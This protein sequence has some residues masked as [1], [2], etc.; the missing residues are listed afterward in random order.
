MKTRI[1]LLSFLIVFCVT[2]NASEYKSY[3]VK[4][5][6]N[7]G[8]LI[9][10][11]QKK[12]MINAPFN[13]GGSW[14]VIVPS[15]ETLN[16]I[17]TAQAPFNNLD[18]IL[19]THAHEDHYNSDMLE[20]TML[21]NP[22]AWLVVPPEL[23]TILENDW[24]NFES[25]KNRIVHP[26][27]AWKTSEELS[28]N[29]VELKIYCEKHHLPDASG[30]KN[31]AY[32][33]NLDGYKILHN[34]ASSSLDY[35]GEYNN[36]DMQNENIDLAILHYFM[37]TSN[38]WTGSSTLSL[39][40]NKVEFV[41]QY[42]NPKNIELAHVYYMNSAYPLLLD[43]LKG[44]ADLP[45]VHIFRN[46]L[47]GKIY[48]S[49]SIDY[50]GQQSPGNTPSLF[51]PEVVSV[52][53]RNERCL[54]VSPEGDELFFSTF[55]NNWDWSVPLYY[56]KENDTWIEKDLPSN[57]ADYASFTEPFFSPDGRRLY[58]SCNEPGDN[59]KYNNRLWVISK[60]NTAW[61]DPVL[62]PAA[63]NFHK[64]LW[65]PSIADNEN[66][67]FAYNGRI[68]CAEF[69]DGAYQNAVPL[70]KTINAGAQNWDPYIDPNEQFILFKSNKAGGYGQ[71]DMYISFKNK[72]HEWT[73]LKNFGP[74]INNEE[75]NDA[76][77]VTPDGKY[78]TYSVI[79]PNNAT[80][81]Y[82]VEFAHLFDSLRSSDYVPYLKNEIEDQV[83]QVNKRFSFKFSGY[84]IDDGEEE[85]SYTAT[86]A[87]GDPLPEWLELEQ[88]YQR[89]SG[90]PTESES[91]EVQLSAADSMNAPLSTKFKI[92]VEGT[93]GL[94]QKKN[95][96][97]EIYPNPARNN[98]WLKGCEIGNSYF[99]L[100]S[101]S[102]QKIS[103]G[104]ILDKKIDLPALG[105]GVYLFVVESDK[106]KMIQKL[107][108]E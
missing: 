79:K 45:P 22:N 10:S 100:N 62:L 16:K 58:F 35:S 50:F 82:W 13:T 57:L 103:E 55:D 38:I 77:D 60:E 33:M 107:M 20:A 6:G 94:I 86:L 23:Y 27:I 85:L 90:T 65:H 66:F 53:E 67:Y 42:I 78:L 108:V 76:G 43:M 31:Y 68:Y 5:I 14:G 74:V 24:E 64:G 12:I 92:T 56:Q 3:R 101:L 81:M 99:S 51:A 11:S 39:L 80:N 17:C 37:F 89:L 32:L 91:F 47:E 18:L 98:V 15:S 61:S 105:P 75:N 8:Y 104:M 97:I 46:S 30:V 34:G 71:M 2:A 102:G 4:F 52:E 69:V 21:S 49:G 93:T 9:T 7:S 25:L 73:N 19:I 83:A 70:P 36:F 106:Q 88:D 95:S 84:F 41:K 40:E 26:D 54:S 1:L 59:V 72:K 63:I 29:G 48:S 44:R 96:A 87:N 28:V